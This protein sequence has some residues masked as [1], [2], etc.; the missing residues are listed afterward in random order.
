MKNIIT[1]ILLIL[2]TSCGARKVNIEKLSIKKDSIATT[3]IVVTTDIEKKLVDT[4]NI[5]MQVE[6]DEIT[7]TPID[8][9]KEIVVDG[10]KYKNVIIRRKKVKDNS[11]YVNSKRESE[12]KRKDSTASIVVTKKD[13]TDGRSKFID[14][15]E[16]VVGNIV[17]YSLLLLFWI[18]IILFIRKTYKTYIA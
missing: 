13:A 18:I 17:V 1:I 15:K 9:S 14:K 8:S 4:T 12:T 2:I 3:D 5:K 16:S 11:L 10:K 6:T 7:L